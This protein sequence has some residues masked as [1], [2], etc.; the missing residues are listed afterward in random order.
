MLDSAALHPGR[1]ARAQLAAAAA[2]SRLPR[3]AVRAALNLLALADTADRRGGAL[4]YGMAR[5]VSLASALLAD[6]LTLVLDE[7]FN[8][9]DPEGVRWLRGLLRERAAQGATVL[10]SSHVMSEI[11]SVADRILVLAGGE[12]V[13]DAPLDRFLAQHVNPRVEV[14]SDDQPR[15]AAAL[16]HQGV[17]TRMQPD[18]SLLV[19]GATAVEVGRLA[20]ALG[21]AIFGLRSLAADLETAYFQSI[22][23]T[24]D[25]AEGD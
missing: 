12:L 19:H 25:L 21:V 17:D 11:S 5:R 6:P 13:A 22:E 10:L 8:G 18:G 1:S 20:L 16:A 14:H 3:E 9:L 4:S 24:T 2:G 15:L 7:P 23:A